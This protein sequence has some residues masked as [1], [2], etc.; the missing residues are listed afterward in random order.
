MV[1]LE[2]VQLDRRVEERLVGRCHDTGLDFLHGDDVLA[3]GG[4]KKRR[5]NERWT[6]RCVAK[7]SERSVDAHEIKVKGEERYGIVVGLPWEDHQDDDIKQLR[8]GFL[9]R[10]G[11]SRPP[12]KIATF[13]AR[14]GHG[15][16]AEM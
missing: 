16:T 10:H 3:L 6:P 2:E 12:R 13:L 15:C 11:C 8:R 14:K 1:N 5:R 7:K 4:H 9:S